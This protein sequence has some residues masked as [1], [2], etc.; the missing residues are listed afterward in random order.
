MDKDFDFQRIN[1]GKFATCP[2][3]SIDVAIMEKTNRVGSY[4]LI[5]VGVILAIGILFG[6]IH[7][8]MLMEIL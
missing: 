7:Q 8:K 5:L 6:K 4:L 1:K 2:N 3:T